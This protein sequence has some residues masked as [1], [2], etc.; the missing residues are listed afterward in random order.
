MADITHQQ[1]HELSQPLPILQS[2]RNLIIAML[3]RMNR[4]KPSEIADVV[5]QD[6]LFTAQV[7]RI[8]N[9]RA[10]T[11]L[12]ADISAVESAIL[13]LG[14]EPFLHRFARHTTVE[15]LMLPEQQQEYA[16]LLRW[17]FNARVMRRISKDF[18]IQRYDSKVDAV[19]IAGLLRALKNILPLITP[20]VSETD[21]VSLLT[22]WQ[23]PTA[24]VELLGPMPEPTPR[25]ALQ[26]ALFSVMDCLEKGWWLP[27]VQTNLQTIALLLGKENGDIWQTV[28]RILLAQTREMTGKT[29]FFSAARWLV[30][31]PG[32]WPVSVVKRQA[33]AQ[34]LSQEAIKPAPLPVE[35]PS[36]TYKP[37]KIEKDLL[38]E[39]MKALHQAGVQGA[40]TN[41]VMSLA[42]RAMAD[43][44]GMQRIV[45]ALFMAGENALR[46]RYV[47][48]QGMEGLRQLVL[49]L[50]EMHLFTR[51]L[52]KQSSIWLNTTNYQQYQPILPIEFKS[53]LDAKSFCSMSIFVA[54]KPVGLLYADPGPQDQVSEHQYQYFKQISTMVSRALAHNARRSTA[55]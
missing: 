22:A 6:P 21:L 15:S 34:Q 37:V 29:S 5:L 8:V 42:I 13:L 39:R 32:E 4:I 23:F 49:S 16:S 11:P 45:F 10:R 53:Q 19:Q 44:L 1:Q 52:Q 46:F 43:G 38:L 9:H 35:E 7:L 33:P 25:Y 18:A 17:V 55:A 24:I 47:Q 14:V 41:Q 51:L 28:V 54:D 31:Q 30:M 50:D 36:H 27:Q 40:P 48:G 26:K 2:S 12:A 3:K 20:S